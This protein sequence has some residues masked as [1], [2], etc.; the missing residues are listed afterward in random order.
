MRGVCVSVCERVYGVSVCLEVVSKRRQRE[1][2]RERERER[3][4]G[5]RERPRRRMEGAALRQGATTDGCESTLRGRDRTLNIRATAA[6]E[7]SAT[8]DGVRESE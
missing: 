7:Q 6:S 1:R 8:A 4:K 2:E 3:G 5:G